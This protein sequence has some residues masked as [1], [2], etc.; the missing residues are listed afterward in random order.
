MKKI[1]PCYCCGN[2]CY[3]LSPFSLNLCQSCAFEIVPEDA[4]RSDSFDLS[5]PRDGN[6][7]PYRT[8]HA[9]LDAVKQRK[10]IK[11]TIPNL[12]SKKYLG[13][14]PCGIHHSVCIYHK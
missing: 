2:E 14:C 13:Q 1:V 11:A 6:G 4:S 12:G 9:E 8:W 7:F 3:E 10:T 5:D